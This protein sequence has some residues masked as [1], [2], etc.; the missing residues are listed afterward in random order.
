VGTLND[1]DYRH[2]PAKAHDSRWVHRPFA[3]P[4]RTEQRHDAS[5]VAGQIY[6]RLRHLIQVRRENQALAGIEAGVI[7]TG[8][9]HVFGY[10]R[11]HEGERI[12]VLANF[13]EAEQRIDANGLR[14]HGL[15]Y[16]FTD[17]VSGASVTAEGQLVI[18]PLGFVWLK[19][20]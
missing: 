14:L 8:S 18:E 10:V 17:L 9:P 12:I 11:R 4:Q 2:D 6:S 19:A 13:A 15:S 1:Y 16:R 5:T 20:E 7:D 3:D